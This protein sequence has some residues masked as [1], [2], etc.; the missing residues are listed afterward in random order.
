LQPKGQPLTRPAFTLASILPAIELLRQFCALSALALECK[1]PIWEAT[2]LCLK[3]T[4]RF[5]HTFLGK[6]RHTF[7]NIL[8]HKM[9]YPKDILFVFMFV[10]IW[11]NF[12]FPKEFLLTLK[13]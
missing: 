10:L 3:F 6:D 13:R 1:W 12:A 4:G 9:N 7:K 5:S 11:R 2:W 8:S